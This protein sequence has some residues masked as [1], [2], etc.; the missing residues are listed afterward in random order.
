MARGGDVPEAEQLSDAEF[1]DHVPELLDRL[2]ERLRSQ[3][4]D[5]ASEGKRHGRVRWRQG[6]D[7]AEIVM[8]YGHLRTAL[9]RATADFA[10]STAGTLP[11]S[12]RSPRRSTTS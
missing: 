5:A 11:G 6:Y 8:E 4:S 7:I 2:A 9:S 3:P 10:P 12:R 1:L